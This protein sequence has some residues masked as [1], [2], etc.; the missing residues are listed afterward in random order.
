L[1]LLEKLVQVNGEEM[2][3]LCRVRGSRERLAAVVEVKQSAPWEYISG[4]LSDM[5][6]HTPF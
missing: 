4:E 6:F 5:F 2:V 3:R 1:G